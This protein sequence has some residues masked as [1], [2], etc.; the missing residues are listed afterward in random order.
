[1][2]PLMTVTRLATIAVM[3]WGALCVPAVTFAQGPGLIAREPGVIIGTVTDS[4]KQRL[5]G[6]TI[7]IKTADGVLSVVT[8]VQGRY[9]IAGLPLGAHRVVAE[10]RGFGLTA[11]Q[12]ELTSRYPESDVSLVMY[13]GPLEDSHT[14]PPPG[15]PAPPWRYRVWPLGPE[16]R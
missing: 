7:T 15:G 13:V 2:S 16:S 3:L 1:M 14:V 12:V 10:L 4:S 8:D 9:R 6:V 5:P 11:K